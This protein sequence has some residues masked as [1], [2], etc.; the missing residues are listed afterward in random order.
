VL[1]HERA[2]TH[3]AVLKP[4]ALPLSYTPVMARKGACMSNV[5]KRVSNGP[6]CMPS[7]FSEYA[8]VG[9]GCGVGKGMSLDAALHLVPSH[10]EPSRHETGM[11]PQFPLASTS[12]PGGHS[13]A[14]PHRECKDLNPAA[15]TRRKPQRQA[16]ATQ[17]RGAATKHRIER[18]AYREHCRAAERRAQ[19]ARP[20]WR[21]RLAWSCFWFTVWSPLWHN[22]E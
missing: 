15:S 6:A 12:V 3:D 10:S 19:A 1:R 5:S 2:I 7:N 13:T 11:R 20:A 4:I 14:A 16:A 9:E 18:A 22:G 21:A 17:R 8:T